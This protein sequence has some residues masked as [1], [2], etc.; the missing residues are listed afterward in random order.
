M[1][2]AQASGRL[3]IT[4]ARVFDAACAT[5]L[6]ERTIVVEGDRIAAV[7]VPARVAARPGER[8]LDGRGKY[9]LPGFVDAHMHVNHV[10]TDA[11]MTGD[12]LLPYY[13]AAGV[14]T[15]SSGGDELIAERLVE[16]FA[17]SH[18]QSCPRL[19]L[20]SPLV[21]GDPPYHRRSGYAVTDPG[22]VGSFVDETAAWGVTTFKIYVGTGRAVG[23]EL[24]AQAHGRGKRVIGHLGQYTAQDAAADGIDCLEHIASVFNFILP[25]DAPVMPLAPERARMDPKVV[26]DL[27]LRVARAR[28][29]AD[30][31][32]PRVKALIDLLLENHVRVAPTLVVYRNWM[33]L[34]DAPEIYGHPDNDRM[35]ARLKELW[36]S[37]RLQS[38]P[39]PE[40]AELRRMELQ[41]LQRLTRL[42]ADAG[43]ELLVG[44]DS[45]VAF[46]PPGLALHQELKLLADSGL[47]P[48]KV[49]Q[50]ATLIN[51]RALG[52][53]SDLGSIEP[54]KLADLLV[55]D[56][57]PVA[58][59][60]NTRRIHKVIRGGLLCDPATILAT[61]QP[62]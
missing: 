32:H 39:E 30:L 55:L 49:L 2:Y 20:A 15:V 58:H 14:T 29:E 6:D 41:K 9:V 57:D 61:I 19:I 52:R 42:L 54:G 4:G 37:Q 27:R 16:K 36:Q 44:T 35:P 43:V 62:R 56:A 13:L 59:I 34:R 11:H 5:F 12:E 8:R 28:A 1:P 40:T 23:R 45:P 24:I 25:P 17:E 53:E 60:E 3:L 22:L 38:A 26:R 31:D 46:C 51:A 50:C 33:L 7:D 18:P 21:D 48:A 47:A 10:V